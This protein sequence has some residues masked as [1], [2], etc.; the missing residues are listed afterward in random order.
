MPN[1]IDAVILDIEPNYVIDVCVVGTIL[2]YR[3]A[4][5]EAEGVKQEYTFTAKTADEIIKHKVGD[6]FLLWC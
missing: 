2:Y 4:V 6:T 5:I 3:K 1:Q